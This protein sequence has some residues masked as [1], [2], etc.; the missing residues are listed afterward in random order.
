MLRDAIIFSSKL[1][2]KNQK[3]KLLEP[4]WKRCRNHH[5]WKFFSFGL[6]CGYVGATTS[7]STVHE[8]VSVLKFVFAVGRLNI[9]WYEINNIILH[10]LEMSVEELLEAVRPFLEVFRKHIQIWW[11]SALMCISRLW[12]F[13]FSI[14]CLSITMCRNGIDPIAVWI[15][16]IRISSKISD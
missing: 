12:I 8:Y 9:F 4:S 2:R 15:C 6:K 10:L 5:T 14:H 3:D 16:C 11:P 7:R 1:H 13:Q